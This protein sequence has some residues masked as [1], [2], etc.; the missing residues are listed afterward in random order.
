MM[1]CDDARLWW[2]GDRFLV[3]TCDLLLGG[4]SCSHFFSLVNMGGLSHHHGRPARMYMEYVRAC[5]AYVQ[6]ETESVF[7]DA[8]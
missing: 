8:S 3:F 7:T 1:M 4:V 6:I 2:C 5:V